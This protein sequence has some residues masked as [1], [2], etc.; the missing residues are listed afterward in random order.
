[1]GRLRRM[2]AETFHGPFRAITFLSLRATDEPA[3]YRR[4]LCFRIST[5]Q[6]QTTRMPEKDSKHSLADLLGKGAYLPP[7]API[8]PQQV[9]NMAPNEDEAPQRVAP[10][11]KPGKH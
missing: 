6:H 2:R 8:L 1:M 7:L 4:L 11:R 5:P 10:R 9:V 3:L